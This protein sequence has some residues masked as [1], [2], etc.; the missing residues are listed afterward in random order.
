M[1][2]SPQAVTQEWGLKIHTV[3][4]AVFCSLLFYSTCFC[5]LF[6]VGTVEITVLLPIVYYSTKPRSIC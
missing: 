4:N 6:I 3:R 1:F 5:V 2:M